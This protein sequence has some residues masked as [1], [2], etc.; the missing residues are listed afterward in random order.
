MKKYITALLLALFNS[1]WVFFWWKSYENKNTDHGYAPAIFII[2]ILVTTGIVFLGSQILTYLK[3][4]NWKLLLLIGIINLFWV[5]R[6]LQTGINHWSMYI[7][8]IFIAIT[9]AIIC[10]GNWIYHKLIKKTKNV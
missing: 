6:F 10:L 2:L 9:T 8:I 4:K 1:P 7:L 5:I 3:Q